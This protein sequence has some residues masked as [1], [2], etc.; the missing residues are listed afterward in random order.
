VILGTDDLSGS[1]SLSNVDLY[2]NTGG[3]IANIVCREHHSYEFY[4]KCGYS[5]IGV[6]PDANGIGK[7]DILMGKSVGKKPSAGRASLTALDGGKK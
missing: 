3:R 4:L 1:T 2:D 7:P 6:V 5:I